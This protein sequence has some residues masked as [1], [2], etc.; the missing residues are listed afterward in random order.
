M[1]QTKLI[2]FS[3]SNKQQIPISYFNYLKHCRENIHE[4]YEDKIIQSSRVGHFG[5]VFAG[6]QTHKCH[7]KDRSNAYK[8]AYLHIKNNNILLP[9]NILSEVASL[10]SQN[11][12]HDM[13]TN[14]MQG[15]YTCIYIHIYN[16]YS[17]SYKQFSSL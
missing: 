14:R 7:G 3:L 8:K 15:P 2:I 5:K 10:F 1:N 16:T 6:F 9:K 11:D 13:T 17:N 12:T 4:R